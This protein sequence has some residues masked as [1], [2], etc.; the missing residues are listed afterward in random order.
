MRLQLYS[1]PT[2]QIR[3][4]GHQGV[5][6][7]GCVFCLLESLGIHVSMRYHTPPLEVL[8]IEASNSRHQT[9]DVLQRSAPNSQCLTKE[10]VNPSLSTKFQQAHKQLS[11]QIQDSSIF[12]D[13]FVLRSD[14]VLQKSNPRSTKPGHLRVGFVSSGVA[15]L[16]GWNRVSSKDRSQTWSNS[17]KVGK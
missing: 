16:V 3:R 8:H 12:F 11:G 7:V 5:G 6:L 9:S 1:A 17:R 10:G 2:I 15:Q 4:A 13:R 14:V